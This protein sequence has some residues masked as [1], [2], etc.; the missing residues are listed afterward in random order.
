MIDIEGGYT[1]KFI[2]PYAVGLSFSGFRTTNELKQAMHSNLAPSHSNNSINTEGMH[3]KG[4]K[5]K[6]P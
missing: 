3:I 6:K 4:K 2:F 1:T 5:V